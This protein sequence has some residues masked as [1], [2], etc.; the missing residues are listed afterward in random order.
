MN[1]I[2]TTVDKEKLQIKMER[3]F[4]APLERLWQAHADPNLGLKKRLSEFIALAESVDF[5]AETVV[6][7][8]KTEFVRADYRGQSAE[9]KQLYRL[10]REPVLV[11]RDLARGWLSELN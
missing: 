3:V 1:S 8:N 4:D 6:Q 5:N 7:G 9:W 11:A 2:V 10:G